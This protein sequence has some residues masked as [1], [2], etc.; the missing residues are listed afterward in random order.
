[1]KMFENTDYIALSMSD[2]SVRKKSLKRVNFRCT[3]F[4]SI[5]FFE[6]FCKVFVGFLGFFLF[7]SSTCFFSL[8]AMEP[9]F[10]IPEEPLLDR[11]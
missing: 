11:C 9:A 6:G 7:A 10:E 2:D 8:A 3:S 1:M 5:V 4:D